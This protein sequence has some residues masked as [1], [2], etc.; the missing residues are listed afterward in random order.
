M[1]AERINA[2]ILLLKAKAIETYGL[3]KQCSTK[4]AESGDSD[5][6]AKLALNLV[7]FEGAML[8]LQQYKNELLAEPDPKP[9]PET[10]REEKKLVVTEERS[11]TYRRSLEQQS[12]VRKGTKDEQEE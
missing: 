1:S 5:E 12:S 11:P 10:D 6:I 7:Q 4:A 8:T 3:I 2:A 9:E